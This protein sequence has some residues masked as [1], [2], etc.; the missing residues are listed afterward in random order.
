MDQSP[1]VRNFAKAF[2]GNWL[3]MM[4]G[5]PSVPAAIMGLYVQNDTARILL[6]STAA[7]AIILSTYF[8]WR[9]ERERLNATEEDLRSTKSILEKERENNLPKLVGNIEQLGW[10]SVDGL[11]FIMVNMGVKNLGAPSVADQ[12]SAVMVVEGQRHQMALFFIPDTVTIHQMVVTKADGLMDKTIV[13]PIPRGGLIRGWLRAAPTI[14]NNHIITDELLKAPGAAV[15]EISFADVTGAR[16]EALFPFKGKSKV[17]TNFYYPDGTG[18][19]IK[20]AEGA[21]EK[22]G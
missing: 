1:N 19:R 16:S 3:A 21:T 5:G 4:S 12:F 9:A 13:A 7:A 8:V 11:L 18:A 14:E 20:R 17:N 2:F 6:W 22:A 15:L 10:G